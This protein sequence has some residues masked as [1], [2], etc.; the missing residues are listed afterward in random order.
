MRNTSLDMS[1]P[2]NAQ[3]RVNINSALPRPS[4]RRRNTVLD[5]SDEETPERALSESLLAIEITTHAR[6]R[7]KRRAMP[8]DCLAEDEYTSDASTAAPPRQ[9]QANTQI[10]RADTSFENAVDKPRMST[11]STPRCLRENCRCGGHVWCSK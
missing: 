3:G 4:N 11:S 10:Q 8:P 7:R 6:H 9:H 1:T 5:S 2:Q